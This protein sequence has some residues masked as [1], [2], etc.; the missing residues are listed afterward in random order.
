MNGPKYSTADIAKGAQADRD[1]EHEREQA[2]RDRLERERER[3]QTREHLESKEPPRVDRADGV[4]Q[5]IAEREAAAQ[6][7]QRE[8][9]QRASTGARAA[10]GA[11]TG[12]T[13]GAAA[14]AARSAAPPAAGPAVPPT[15]RSEAPIAR[16][17]TAEMNAPLFAADAAKDFRTRWDTIQASFVDDPRRAVQEADSLVAETMQRL[18]DT[19]AKERARL[20]QQFERESNVSTEDLRVTLRHYRS[21]FTRL[22]SV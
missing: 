15:A 13:A 12:A 8:A 4:R 3:A 9:A 1:R 7:N 2:E 5:E 20:E 21:F 22:L 16:A 11:M 17:D 18:A 6:A 10:T 19:F 14:A